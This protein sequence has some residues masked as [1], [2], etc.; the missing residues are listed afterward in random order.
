M[1]V[2]QIAAGPKLRF[3]GTQRLRP[4]E[5]TL[6]ALEA[7]RDASGLTR[8]A[9]V[10]G[11][12]YLGIPVCMAVRPLGRRLS[13][14]QGKGLTLP[15]AMVSAA[16]ESLE[17]WHAEYRC[18][19]AQ[20]AARVSE[21]ALAYDIADLQH[22]P[23]SLVTDATEL[24]W[25]PA[26]GMVTGR[27]HLVP[28]QAVAMETRS[29]SSWEAPGLRASSNGL[30]SGNYV[31]EA[32]LHALCEVIERDVLAGY[33]ADRLTAVP[34]DLSLVQ[35]EA[36]SVLSS[37]LDEAGVWWEAA[38]IPNPYDVPTFI[39]HIW[40]EDMPVLGSGSGTHPDASIALCRA[41][42]EAAQSRLTVIAGSRDDLDADLYRGHRRRI[43]APAD[44]ARQHWDSVSWPPPADTFE[45]D[46]DRLA[47]AAATVHGYEPMLVDLSSD[48][49]DLAFV[50]IIAPGTGFEG[51]HTLPR[52]TGAGR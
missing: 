35:D 49:G 41:I 17:M 40:S 23:G 19:A 7:Y 9:D 18:P 30:A 1:T 34:L 27:E 4:P 29:L 45:A 24:D 44:A 50:K 15:L 3:G 2:A 39:T 37:R 11:L 33:R 31:G 21:V 42:T 28:R 47:Q 12:D 26:R 38:A 16:M 46:L 13:V 51:D 36:V 14:A 52:L 10:T 48:L 22:H 32:A 43:Q 25:M 6:A 20:Y 5:A 8:I